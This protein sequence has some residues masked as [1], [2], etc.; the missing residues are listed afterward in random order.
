M[1]ST[2]LK[3]GWLLF[4]T[5]FLNM[6]LSG[7][8]QRCGLDEWVAAQKLKSPEA[9]EQRKLVEKRINN[10]RINNEVSS[11]NLITIPIVV[12][13]VWNKEEENI[14]DAQI[15]SQI[16]VLNEDF[17]AFNIE[18]ADIPSEFRALVADVEFEFCL[19]K[20]NP[21]GQSTTGITRTFTNNI[22]IANNQN[23]IK[24]GTR[25]GA[26]PW[27]TESYVNIWVGRRT[28]GILGISTRPGDDE[29]EGLVIDYRAFGRV[30]E[31]MQNA[32]YNLGRT[33]THEIGHYFNLKHLWGEGFDNDNCNQDD[34]IAD[35]PL[36]STTYNSMCPQTAQ[37]SCGSSDMF[38]NFMNYT[39]D[40][41]MGLFTLGQKEQM[42]A[43]LFSVRTGILAS[44]TCDENISNTQLASISPFQI[45]PNPAQHQ[46]I[47]DTELEAESL[48]II[49]SLGQVCLE[50]DAPMA[51]QINI[52]HLPTGYYQVLISVEDRFIA[53][54]LLIQK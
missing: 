16:E 12:H 25:G 53:Q 36:Q 23:L 52:S 45:Y 33:T 1:F 50:I 49:N 46:F 43:T 13:V 19:A 7:Q 24:Y 54:P 34:D 37:F 8:F 18:V 40:A 5:I 51:K 22:G 28:D 35:T 11:R 15:A 30:G 39:N 17:R 3:M 21:S 44:H 2:V 6:A 9:V 38:M 32:P 41:C 42:V 4:F 31:A 10:W 27:D 29:I 26:D 47:V 14:S 20:I 48:K